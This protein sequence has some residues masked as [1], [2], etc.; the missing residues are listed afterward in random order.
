MK[1]TPETLRVSSTDKKWVPINP[2]STFPLLLKRAKQ[3]YGD[4]LEIVPY[5]SPYGGSKGYYLKWHSDHKDDLPPE[6]LKHPPNAEEDWELTEFED[7]SEEDILPIE[8]W[9]IYVPT[10]HWG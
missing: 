7:D 8:G 2:R 3:E 10:H 5:A 1:L 4:K 6:E 9:M